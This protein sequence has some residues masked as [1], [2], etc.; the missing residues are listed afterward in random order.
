M[1]LCMILSSCISVFCSKAAVDLATNVSNVTPS[2]S[3][4]S[5]ARPMKSSAMDT[6]I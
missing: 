6:P 3:I 1:D 2:L 5:K 4:E